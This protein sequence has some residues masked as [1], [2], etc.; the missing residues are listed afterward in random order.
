MEYCAESSQKILEVVQAAKAAA[1]EAAQEYEVRAQRAEDL[2]S[3]S[4]RLGDRHNTSRIAD[5]VMAAKKA[6]EG[7]YMAYQN[8]V[9]LVDQ[10]CRPLLEQT[11]SPQAV[12]EVRNLIRWLNDESEIENN[13]SASFNGADLGDLACVRFH[14]TMDNK[15]IQAFWDN[16]YAMW[17]GRQEFEQQ[18][19]DAAQAARA[20]AAQ[21]ARELFRASAGNPQQEQAQYQKNLASWKEKVAQVRWLREEEAKRL[22]TEM[23]DR[24]CSPIRSRWESQI[25]S[26]EDKIATA[27][28]QQLQLTTELESLGA[29]QLGRKMAIKKSLK[30][31]ESFLASMTA[32]L[33]IQ[34]AKMAREVQMAMVQVNREKA[35][36]QAQAEAKYP[37]PEEPCPPGMTRQQMEMIRTEDAILETLKQHPR[38]TQEKLLELC[39]AISGMT[40]I[41]LRAILRRMA[42]ISV[43]EEYYKR[44]YL[45]SFKEGFVRGGGLT[46]EQQENRDRILAYLKANTYGTVAEIADAAN[47]KNERT[48]TTALEMAKEGIL[49]RYEYDRKI[50]FEIF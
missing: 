31:H 43:F 14:P 18:E 9:Q 3:D 49:V 2:A 13:Y 36:F 21:K 41:R 23:E 33:D 30:E 8:L 38:I 44:M 25:R 22:F 7:L 28:A 39:P 16:K 45:Y 5:I 32:E 17:P 10:Q 34:K 46:P 1:K 6:C 40:E 24:V 48:H 37:M 35:A 4:F 15:M 19:A 20:A 47:M 42:G 27:K 29:F 11:P 12:R 50:W 26:T